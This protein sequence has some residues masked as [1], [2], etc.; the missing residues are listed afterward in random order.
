MLRQIRNALM[1]IG[2]FLG[3]IQAATISGTVSDS[4]SGDKLAGIRVQLRS[5]A[6]A[7]ATD[8][9]SSVGAYSFSNVNNGN[10]TITLSNSG[11]EQKSVTTS[12][13]DSNVTV[14][15]KL[16]AIVSVKISGVVTDSATGKALSGAVVSLGSFVNVI[17]DTTGTDGSYT[18][19]GVGNGTQ[20]ITVSMAGYTTRTVSVS[21]AGTSKTQNIALVAIVQTT[22]SGKVTDSLS[23]NAL[24]GAIVSLGTQ[25]GQSAIRDTAGTDGSYTLSGVASGN[26]RITA[27][28][29]GYTSKTITVNVTSSS[30]VT[31]NITLFKPITTTVSGKVTDS[32]TGKALARVSVNIGSGQTI[33]RATTDTSGSYSISGVA[34]GSQTITASLTGYISKSVTVNITSSTPVTQNI[35]LNAI[36]ET[37][38]KGKIT[39][40]ISG[41]AVSGVVVLIGT[42]MRALRDTTGSDGSYAFDSVLSGPQTI[43]V[44]K[45]GYLPKTI[46][47]SLSGTPNVQDI[48]INKIVATTVVG[49]VTDSVSG[50][51]LK[52][53]IVRL[54][55]SGL[56]SRR[57]TTGTDGAYSFD[58]VMSGSQTLQVSLAGYITKSV[59]VTV[60]GSKPFTVNIAL[61]PLTIAVNHGLKAKTGEPVMNITENGDIKFNNFSLPGELKIF[62][63]SG[64]LVYEQA[65]NSSVSIVRLPQYISTSGNI[66]K[67]TA[68]N[69]V[70]INRITSIK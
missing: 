63:L 65:I 38:V 36:V 1:V 59:T 46:T 7:V 16:V 19:S 68:G 21:I 35:A 37:S 70:Y 33:R 50:A 24:A 8:T 13:R 22:I 43:S 49:K 56:N 55:G 47:V 30:P 17:R 9:T 60:V 26:Q 44:S 11:Y 41:E 5:G 15:V 48:A 45:N 62:N 53:A 69:K 34:G 54:I 29:T 66:V 3:T 20:I 28:L 57:D 67:F 10:Y 25:Y 51:A 58:S 14:D 32:I 2:L 23:G 18:L 40:S 39:D 61:R 27:S 31:Q 42:G 52:G 4:S 12:V 64:K 6:R